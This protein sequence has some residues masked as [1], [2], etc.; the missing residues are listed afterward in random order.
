MPML[1]FSSHFCRGRLLTAFVFSAPGD[2]E[3]HSNR[4]VAGDTG[5]NL[6]LALEYMHAIAPASFGSACRY[7]YRISN[8]F[9]SPIAV[10]LGDAASEA[11]RAQ[12]LDP[13]NINRVVAEL[14]ECTVVVLCGRKAQLLSSHVTMPGRTVVHAWH[15]G[16]KALNRKYKIAATL[17][18]ASPDTRRRRRTELWAQDVLFALSDKM[19]VA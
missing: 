11:S 4:P 17:A 14:S 10:S 8:A 18:T 13:L 7:D 2:E 6:A 5:M 15:T 9:A 16:N 12:I 3:K 1:D 19:H